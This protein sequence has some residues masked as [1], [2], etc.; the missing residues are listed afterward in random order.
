MPL[1]GTEQCKRSNLEIGFL[2]FNLESLQEVSRLSV[3]KITIKT[4][5][6]TYIF[7][8]YPGEVKIPW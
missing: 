3:I 4:F 8:H 5:M 7:L 6:D 1:T 2:F